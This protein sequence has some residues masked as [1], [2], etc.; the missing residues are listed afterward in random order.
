MCPIKRIVISSLLVVCLNGCHC[1]DPVTPPPSPVGLYAGTYA[2]VVQGT[3]SSLVHYMIWVFT[4]KQFYMDYDT[5][6]YSNQ[7]DAQVCDVGG[8]YEIEAG[9]T[10]TADSSQDSTRT[11]R[12]CTKSY[13][14]FGMYQLNQSVEGEITMTSLTQNLQGNNVI[15]TIHLVRK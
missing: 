6:H 3:D 14:P 10:L 9:I 13:A 11:D 8:R 5:T 1:G 12:V 7:A 15:R 2:R 4:D